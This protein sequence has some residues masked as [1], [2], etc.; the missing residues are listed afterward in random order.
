[1]EL[2]ERL[3]GHVTD[4]CEDVSVKET[5]RAYSRNI[6]Q[7]QEMPYYMGRDNAKMSENKS[8]GQGTLESL[9]QWNTASL[10]SHG[11]ASAAARPKTKLALHGRMR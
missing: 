10:G 11:G 3:L 6:G 7:S 5:L 2:S 4:A 9:Y 1:M 8:M